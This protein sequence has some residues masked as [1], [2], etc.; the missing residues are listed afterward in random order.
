[1]YCFHTF[2]LNKELQYVRNMPIS[3]IMSEM[4]FQI[5]TV[6]H[7]SQKVDDWSIPTNKLIKIFTVTCL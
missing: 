3:L 7:I 5:H 4:H 6:V 2:A 1:M